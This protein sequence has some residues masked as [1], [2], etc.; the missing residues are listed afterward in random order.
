MAL[1]SACTR[2][3]KVPWVPLQK[4]EPVPPELDE[5]ELPLEDELDVPAE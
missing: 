2:P 3:K 4:V 1:P 5:D